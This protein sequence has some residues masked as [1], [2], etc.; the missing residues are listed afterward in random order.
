MQKRGYKLLVALAVPM[1][2]IAG[3]GAAQAEIITFANNAGQEGGTF[4]I[5]G[6]VR[7]VRPHLGRGAAGRRFGG[8]HGYLRHLRAASSWSPAPTWGRTPAPLPTTTSTREP[9]A[10]S[11]LSGRR[12]EREHRAPSIRACTI[13][14]ATSG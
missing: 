6:T 2:L 4:S 10:R 14:P 1:A 9:A 13:P 12:P 7:S 5:G 11:R 8:R 3:S